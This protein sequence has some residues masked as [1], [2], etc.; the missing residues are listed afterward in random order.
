MKRNPLALKSKI[1][2]LICSH[3]KNRKSSNLII[4]KNEF[5][6]I[7]NQDYED[8]LYG[9]ENN[10]NNFYNHEEDNICR[11]NNLNFYDSSDY[12]KYNINDIEDILSFPN[13]NDS[14]KKLDYNEN[15]NKKNQSVV[16]LNRDSNNDNS[17]NSNS[18]L[19]NFDLLEN[20]INDNSYIEYKNKKNK[21][22]VKTLYSNEDISIKY[23]YI[24]KKLI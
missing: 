21:I 6:S 5:S 12:Y 18:N 19:I 22:K 4:H 13:I 14:F 1:E 10:S 7:N 2:C 8:D 16:G 11:K 20:N 17:Q 3:K 24:L 9:L 15:A 23:N